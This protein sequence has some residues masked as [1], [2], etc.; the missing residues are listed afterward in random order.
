MPAPIERLITA[1]RLEEGI[2]TSANTPA[3]KCN[4][5][6]GCPCFL[7]FAMICGGL[8]CVVVKVHW[9]LN[10]IQSKGMIVEV[11]CSGVGAL[12]TANQFHHLQGCRYN[13]TYAKETS[14]ARHMVGE[15]ELDTKRPCNAGQAQLLKKLIPG[16]EVSFLGNVKSGTLQP[17]KS[18]G[19]VPISICILEKGS[20]SAG[21]MIEQQKVK[22]AFGF[23]MLFPSMFLC[24]VWC[25]HCAF[26][27]QYAARSLRDGNCGFPTNH[28]VFPRVTTIAAIAALVS[29]LSHIL[30]VILGNTAGYLVTLLVI[31][32]ALHLSFIDDLPGRLM[33]TSSQS[34]DTEAN[35][36][37]EVDN[38]TSTAATTTS[39]PP[40][41]N[42]NERYSPPTE[43][44]PLLEE[45]TSSQPE[46]EPHLGEEQGRS[47]CDELMCAVV[48]GLVAGLAGFSVIAFLLT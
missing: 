7:L 21:T 17:F 28:T 32:V 43:S 25:A 38:A 2:W 20:L 37:E 10:E 44:S 26:F 14:V 33:P 18:P 6:I 39:A 24:L 9:Q 46:T 48:L 30:R 16:Q 8:P 12:P 45:G 4:I 22:S 34:D 19:A 5:L 35:S 31:V 3:A 13:F 23:L 40:T 27:P 42:L 15:F 29:L 47:S 41:A 1:S 36:L 11:P